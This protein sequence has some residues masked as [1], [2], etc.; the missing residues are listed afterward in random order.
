TLKHGIKAEV[1]MASRCYAKAS[2]LIVDGYNFAV[3]KCCIENRA[4]ATKT[5]CSKG[6][7]LWYLSHAMS[8]MSVSL[9]YAA[10]KLS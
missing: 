9:L 8:S 7:W 4:K 1:F 10:K 2:N 5:N 6:L 3:P